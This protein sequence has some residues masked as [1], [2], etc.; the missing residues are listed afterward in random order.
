VNELVTHLLIEVNENLGVGLRSE[1]VAA[2]REVTPE[3]DVVEDFPVEDDL[4][5]TVFVGEGLT[6]AGR[7]DDA[8]PTMCES[9]AWRASIDVHTLTVGTTMGEG[10]AHRPQSRNGDPR[11]IAVE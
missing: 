3:F 10:I 1:V 5:G 9:N 6:A 11:G 4:D 7:V 2:C 8:E